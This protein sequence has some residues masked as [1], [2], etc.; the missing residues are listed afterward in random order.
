MKHAEKKCCRL[1]SGRIPFSPEASLW[2]RQCQVYRSLLRWHNGKLRNYGNLH[3]TARRCQINAPFQLTVKDIK[4]CMVICKEKC[5]YFRKHGQCHRRQ[6]LTNYLEAAQDRADKAAERNILAIIKRE[7]DKAFWRRLN[8]ALGKHV[9][10]QSVRVVQ[11]ED[12]AG[13]V[14][15]FNSEEEV[16]EAI[17]NEVHRKQYNL[18]EEAPICQGALRGQFGYS[19]TTGIARSVLDGTYEFPPDID[20]ATRELFEEIAQIRGMVPSDSVT[21]LIS[22]ERWQQ[23]W[24]SV[25]EDTSSSQSGL[26]FGH[27]IAGTDCNY[28]SQ[29]HALRVSLALKI[30]IAMERWTKGLSVMLEKMFDVRLVSKLQAILLME[31]DFNAMNKE[32]YGVRMLDNARRYNLILEEIFSKKNRTADDGGLAKTLFYDITRQMRAPAA[33][34]SVDA[35]NCY[36]QIAHAMASLI[37]Q[38][39]GV[40]S[41]AVSAMLE[42]IQEMKFFLGTAY[43]DSKRFAGSSIE[44]KMQGLGQ[45]NGA[46][47][48]GRCAIRIVIL[49]AHGAKG[50]GA[51]FIAPMSQV[52]RSLSAILYVDNTDLI[53]INMEADESIGEVHAAIQR[54]RT[55][56]AC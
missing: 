1:K 36:D 54:D 35:A 18:A 24:G 30:G 2:L 15:N 4:L 45:G 8:Y 44:I 32:V 41:T 48:A 40:E 19:A 6:H 5:D 11:V 3:H 31:A 46:A 17:F 55:G 26:H 37:F 7:K 39:F 43:G 21:G 10:G 38:S 42:T 51:H 27:Y 53:H 9:R 16:Q 50:H 22:R 13:G 28:I 56:A 25:K 49:R 12:G 23:R 47:P 52:R 33:I 14:L 20:A 29:F 34:V